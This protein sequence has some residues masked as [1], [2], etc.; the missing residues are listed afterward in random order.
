MPSTQSIINSNLIALGFSNPSQT[1]IFA[2]TS[3]ALGNVIDT[4]LT[5]FTNTQNTITATITAKNYGKAGYYEAYALA[6]QYGDSLSIDA[7]GNYYYATIDT[8]K[9]I[10][11]QAAFYATDNG[12]LFLK[13]ASADIT[14]VT[15]P[16]T[17][18]QYNAFVSYMKIFEI[19][20]LPVNYISTIP[21]ILFFVANCTYYT[22]FD[23]T[24]LTANIQTYLTLFMNSF[25]FNGIFYIDDLSN[26]IKTNVAGVRDFFIS[27]TLLDNDPFSGSVNL[28]SGYFNYSSSNSI[29][30]NGI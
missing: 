4:T 6:F 22:S 8:T 13:V 17:L 19:A 29:T 10:I 23:Y 28:S 25:A 18:S 7:N 14:G 1:G 21:N 15:I 26:Y 11:K 12:D 30:Y 27:Q 2:K 3:E 16:L 5:E 20:G 24:T 9:Q